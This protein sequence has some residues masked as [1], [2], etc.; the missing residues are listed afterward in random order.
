MNIPEDWDLLSPKRQNGEDFEAYRERLKLIKYYERTLKLGIAFSPD[1]G[2]SDNR[3]TE[4]S[5][6]D[7][8]SN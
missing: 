2:S 8:E 5:R 7:I 1:K 6:Q 4:S 3:R